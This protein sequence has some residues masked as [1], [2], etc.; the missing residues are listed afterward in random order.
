[1]SGLVAGRVGRPHGLDGSFYVT[2]AE[3]RL[4]EPGAVVSVAGRRR[5]I[6]RR[7]GTDARPIVR[8]AGCS[9]RDAAEQL[10]GA[11]LTVARESAPQLE[12][13]EWWAEDLIGC[14]V[15]AAQHEIGV[16]RELRALP[17]CEVLVV[18]R[19]GR[20]ALDVPL[21]SDAVIA[22]D[23]AARRIEVDLEF[24]GEEA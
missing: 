9:D 5:E 13:D 2:G 10:R 14:A 6:V 11:E 19:S 18:A 20:A 8:L 4:L 7:A 23:T 3:P 24:L 21:V 17:S 22:V 16:V 15:V 1:M 12:E